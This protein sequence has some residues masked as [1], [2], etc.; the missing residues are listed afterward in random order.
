MIMTRKITYADVQKAVD[1]AYELYKSDNNGSV[2]P[3][4]AAD[5]KPGIFGIS[6]VLTDGRFVD[7][8]DADVLFDLGPIVKIPLSAVL[9][10]Q[11]SPEGLMKKAGVCGCCCMAK[12]HDASGDKVDVPF[13]RHGLKAVSNIEPLGDPEG[14]MKVINDML[15]AMSGCEPAFCDNLYKSLKDEIDKENIAAR[16]TAT[17]KEFP[18]EPSQSLDLYARLL[19]LKMSARQVS[20][21]GATLAADGR[22]PYSGEYAFDGK[23]APYMVTL[24]ATRGRHFIK[25]WLM[26]TGLPAKKSFSGAVTVV[27]PGFGAITAYGPEVDARGISVKGA[28]AIAYIADKLG[29][30]VFASARVEVEK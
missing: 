16:L 4:V 15:V 11:N 9:L 6:L 10:S 27:L 30:N 19:A 7:K 21:M 8:G 3:R 13:G 25:G 29:L 18:E 24:M 28:Q 5:S 20:V 23:I 12:T 17:G 14:K 22:N 26:R 1:E 2:D